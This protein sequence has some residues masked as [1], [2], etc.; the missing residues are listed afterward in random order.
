MAHIQ[1][2]DVVLVHIP[3]IDNSNSMLCKF[4]DTEMIVSK[5]VAVRGY[6][7]AL[8]DSLF[9]YELYGAK[10]DMGVPYGFHPD[11]IIPL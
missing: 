6:R 3:T 8:A 4:Q 1:I 7:L 9:Y 5:K 11:W 10:S 2:G